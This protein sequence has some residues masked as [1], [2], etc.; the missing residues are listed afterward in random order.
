MKD[1]FI[2]K[3]SIKIN[4][5]Q[6]TVVYAKNCT[7]TLTD[8]K[9]NEKTTIHKGHIALLERGLKVYLTIDKYSN[10]TPY[11]IVPLG[12]DKLQGIIKIFEPFNSIEVSKCKLSRGIHEKVFI[13]NNNNTGSFLFNA[14]KQEGGADNQRYIY[15]LAC[16]LSCV[17]D[18]QSLYNSLCVSASDF[19]TDKIRRI[20]ESDLSRKWRLS[21]ISEQLNISEIT[22]RKKLDT[23]GINFNQVLLDVRM[24]AAV[25]LILNGEYHISKIS[26]LI[27]MSSASYFIKVFSNYYGTTPKQFYLYHK[28]NKKTCY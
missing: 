8:K 3:I 20:I 12:N 5:Y 14:I 15:K 24:Q 17:N 1:I 18:M 6:Y 10:D 9:M 4:L 16:L 27:G 7:I 21:A 28:S 11:E 26:S 19:F 2:N 13:I 22:I 25:R 23:E